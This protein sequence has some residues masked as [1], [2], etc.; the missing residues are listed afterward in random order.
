VRYS[1]SEVDAAILQS[2][3]LNTVRLGVMWPG[4][5]PNAGQVNSTYLSNMVAITEMLAAYNITS[6]VDFHQDVLADQLCGEGAPGWAVPLPANPNESFPV[7]VAAPFNVSA[8][9]VPSEAD[10]NLYSWAEY[11]PTCATG[12]AFQALYSNGPT[13]SGGMGMRDAFAQ[14]WSTVA[15]TFRSVSGVL[16]YQIINEP[17][18]GD[19][20]ADPL[21]L[22][23]G[24]A[25][26]VNL[27]PFY[28][29][30]G[31]VIRAADPNRTIFFDSVTWDD[32]IPV[33]FNTTPASLPNTV[34]SFH[35]YIP[36][37]FSVSDQFATRA[38]DAARL[39]SGLFLTE[40]DIGAGGNISAMVETMD[41]VDMYRTSFMGWE[42][43][44]FV[45][46][47]GYGESIYDEQTG[48]F[49]PDVVVALARTYPHFIAG[50]AQSIAFDNDTSVFQLTFLPQPTSPAMLPTEIYVNL[51]LRY[52]NGLNVSISPANGTSWALSQFA[53]AVAN[54]T[55]Y[56]FVHV[57]T[58]P[59]VTSPVSVTIA[60][61]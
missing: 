53:P 12:Q 7:P 59:H 45:Q 3:G 50:R 57:Y 10:C 38:A 58:T 6:L 37:Q 11:Y 41:Y 33:G 56:G 52:P 22:I 5:Y 40:F 49:H 43:K 54:G 55:H 25:D 32:F 60:P 18:A 16:G 44:T 30:I 1:L 17:W 14:Y 21:L 36:P 48:A 34:F 8:G 23:P 28:D 39:G 2:L 24:V 47:T 51:Q 9:G 4:V 26:N 42:Y 35:F 31:P 29:I 13:A 27:Q 46:I 19:A 61:L 20:V 15:T